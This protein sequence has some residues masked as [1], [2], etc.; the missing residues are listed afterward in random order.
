MKL[1]NKKGFTLAE[2]LITLT[3]IGIVAA[4]SLPALNHGVN[5]RLWDTQRKALHSRMSAAILSLPQLKGYGE[6]EAIT[7]GNLTTVTKDTEAESFLIDGL[8]KVYKIKNICDSS[9]MTKCGMPK[10]Y[11]NLA[12]SSKT[13]PTSYFTSRKGAAFATENGESLSVYYNPDCV[14]MNSAIAVD[15][16]HRLTPQKTVCLNFIYDLNGE[17]EP[18]KIGKDMGIMSVV[19][20]PNGLE[21]VAPMPYYKSLGLAPFYKED[22]GDSAGLCKNIGGKY[23]LPTIAEAISITFNSYS[24]GFTGVASSTITSPGSTGSVWYSSQ[25]G[26]YLISKTAANANVVCIKE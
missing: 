7:E 10:T 15:Y 9:N 2:V 19:N 3:V 22:G 12:G 16:N 8:S 25:D 24:T 6:Y 14:K 21:V 5:D 4:I 11:A 20:G 13:L 17:G 23:L 26:A 18:N 1:N